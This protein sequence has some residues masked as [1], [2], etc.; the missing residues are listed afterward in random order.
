MTN[1]VLFYTQV[2]SILLFVVSLFVI[3]RLLVSKKDAAI[4]YLQITNAEKDKLI[5]DLSK[6]TDD[7]LIMNLDQRVKVFDSELKRLNED[8]DKYSKT[9]KQLEKRLSNFDAK[10]KILLLDNPESHI[11]CSECY[12]DLEHWGLSPRQFEV[13]SDRLEDYFDYLYFE[14][15]SKIENGSIVKECTHS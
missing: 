11:F 1:T 4:E 3:Y 2:G 8:R 13:F 12:S 5:S 15:G 10:I 14:C 9:I 6:K 7:Q